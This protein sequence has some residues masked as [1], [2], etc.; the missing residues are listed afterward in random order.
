MTTR[1]LAAALFSVTAFLSAALLFVVQPMVS[2]TLLPVLGGAPAVWNTCLVFFQ[3]AL[4]LGY[5]YA[6][7]TA[8]RLGGRRHVFAHVVW[9]SSDS[10]RYSFMLASIRLESS[11][12][13]NSRLRGS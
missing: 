13:L 8:A 1:A 4:L 11:P 10:A 3:S 12:P 2:K 9:R 6:Y 7:A 5:G